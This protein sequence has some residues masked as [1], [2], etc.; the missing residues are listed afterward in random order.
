MGFPDLL[1]FLASLDQKVMMDV[2]VHLVFLVFL[3]LKVIAVESVQCAVPEWK[4]KK[5]LVDILVCL[6]LK[7]KEGSLEC[8]AF[9]A[10]LVMMV[11]L[12]LPANLDLLAFLEKMDSL[13][14]LDKK[15][16]RHVW[17]SDLA[18]L[19]TLDKKA[20]LDFLA[21]LGLMDNLAKMVFLVL[22]A[23]LAFL[24]QK[25]KQVFLVCLEKLE[26][27]DFQA[28]LDLKANLVMVYPVPLAFLA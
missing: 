14:F 19:V 17:H 7:V 10:I 22:L 25:V 20:K 12:V 16:N 18:L 13:G 4:V 15:V 5:V 24:D 6:D 2:M 3:D 11:F 26:K 27:M 23:C 8:P 9:L 28:Y 21:L 1:V